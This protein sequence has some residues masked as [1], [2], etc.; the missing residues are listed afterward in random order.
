VAAT[1]DDGAAYSG[2][3]EYVDRYVVQRGP[4]VAT[5][6]TAPFTFTAVADSLL[7]LFEEIGAFE[8]VPA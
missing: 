5:R 3:R 6:D 2:L 4:F 1:E 7:E 8:R